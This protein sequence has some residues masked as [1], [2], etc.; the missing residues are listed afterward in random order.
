MDGPESESHKPTFEVQEEDKPLGEP[1]EILNVFRQDGNSYVKVNMAR[2]YNRTPDWRVHEYL[3]RIFDVGDFREKFS[4]TKHGGIV[5]ELDQRVAELDGDST[6]WLERF[7]GLVQ[8]IMGC[9][10]F[11]AKG[12]LADGFQED[13]SDR[14]DTTDNHTKDCKAYSRASQ[15]SMILQHTSTGEST[16][17]LVPARRAD[18]SPVRTSSCGKQ[19]FDF[20]RLDR[21]V[22]TEDEAVR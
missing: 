4:R 21:E 13:G 19:Y 18:M 6:T 1:R 2:D 8:P 14:H 3:P 10:P 16:H 20:L 12:H 15:Q 5:K 9:L 11:K 22:S 17:Q 7:S